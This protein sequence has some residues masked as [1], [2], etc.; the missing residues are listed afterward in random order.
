MIVNL[1]KKVK[2]DAKK[3]E[4]FVES[5]ASVVEEA[6]AR[7]PSLFTVKTEMSLEPKLAAYANE[8]VGSNSS[9]VG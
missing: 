1:Q 9:T 2:I 6:E 7:A 4:P 8:L 5:L 3:F